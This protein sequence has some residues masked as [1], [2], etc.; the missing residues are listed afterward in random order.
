M[1]TRKRLLR[2][3]EQVLNMA[4]ERPTSNPSLGNNNLKNEVGNLLSAANGAATPAPTGP[5]WLP[6]G[7]TITVTNQPGV[8]RS[9]SSAS[10]AAARDGPGPTAGPRHATRY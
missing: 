2:P 4:T 3:P 1:N 7:E 5:A 8:A 9:A 6:H 10:C